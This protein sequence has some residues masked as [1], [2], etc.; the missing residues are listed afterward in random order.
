MAFNVDSAISSAWAVL[1]LIWFV[2]LAFTKRTVRSQPV[3]A[4]LFH[5][6]MV[7]L[8]FALLGSRWFDS[9]W[10]SQRI[11]PV[12]D[13]LK[14]AGVLLTMS[15][16]AFAIWA[17]LTL[18]SNWSGRATVKADHELITRGPYA[19]ARHPIYT[20]ILLGALG[21]SLATCEW[22]CVLGM[23]LLALAFMVKM[24]QEER[25]MMQTFPMD[26]PA[27]RQRVKALVPGVF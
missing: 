1:G 13:E 10:L 22:R 2:G 25:L 19:L 3:G 21:T 24:S 14:I 7:L 5:L 27:Y 23:V 8:G 17:R 18:G 16:C 4:R 15:G 11:L 12:T 26:Y 6:L 20:G 9:G